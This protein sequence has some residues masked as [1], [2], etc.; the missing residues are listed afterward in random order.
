[1]KSNLKLAFGLLLPE[2][3]RNLFVLLLIMLL[4]TL[5]ESAGIGLLLP[6]I[7]LVNSP[8]LLLK[9]GY[10]SSLYQW[11]GL[12]SIREFIIA[13]S[14]FLILLFFFKNIVYVLQNYIQSKLLL[15]LQMSLESRLM[16]QYFRRNYLFFTQKNSSDLVHNIRNVSGIIGLIFMPT[17]TALTELS[18]LVAV[19]LLLILVQPWLTLIAGGFSAL[20]LW[21]IFY[22]TRQRAAKYGVEGGESLASMVKWMHQGFGGIKEV[23]IL[24]KEGFF[25]EQ[26]MRF[27]RMAAWSGM[28]AAMLTMITRPLIETVWFTLTVLLVLVVIALGESGAALL[29]VIA[30]LAAAAI[31]IMPALNRILNSTIA[32]R[33]G[34][35][36][37]EAVA[38]ELS[39]NLSG[40]LEI[41]QTAHKLEFHKDI[42]FA[43]VTFEYP[44]GGGAV[45][46]NISFRINK[47][48][49]VAFVGPSGSGKTTTVDLLLGLLEPQQGHIL[50]DGCP[51]TSKDMRA[52]RRNFGYV[53]QTIYLSDDTIRNNIAFGQLESE[54]DTAMLE[55]VVTQSQ[56]SDLVRSLPMG[57]N[58]VV[59]DR[60][61][62]LSGGQRQRIGIARALYCNPQ[63]LVLDEATSALDNETEREITRAIEDLR[64]SKTL[65][66]IAH[67][68]S[69]V[70]HCD[71]IVFLVDGVIR[72]GGT[73]LEL[74]RDCDEFRRF[75]LAPDSH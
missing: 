39:S 23:K 55:M 21:F 64:G 28:K 15:K 4:V 14:I 11:S 12:A 1:M 46:N 18:V 8:E 48:Q 43:G 51:L 58:T 71:Q 3:Q 75:A 59:G 67:R 32:I 50:V 2:H 45:L 65:V 36:Q 16:A 74:I 60:G 29:P 34:S 37:V 9:N 47:G 69:T 66:L 17:L 33:Q 38:A 68:L 52:W 13:S 57:L 42:H 7:G 5:L 73:Y 49:S 56:L 70:A 72:A 20:L 24:S 31:R 40:S 10:F 30:L 41:E 63:I 6:Y 35:Y 44:S 22:F 53:P 25:L 54:I 19:L 27:S 61:A 62:R 26:S